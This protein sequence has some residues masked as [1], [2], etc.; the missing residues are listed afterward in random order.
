MAERKDLPI[1]PL[2]EKPVANCSWEGCRQKALICEEIEYG[3]GRHNLCEYHWLE[4]HKLAAKRRNA[5]RG[6][7]TVEQMKERCRK[8]G[9]RFKPMPTTDREP[10]QDDEEKVA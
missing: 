4:A 6:L 5:E 7:H 8:L 3:K 1:L 10:G 9:A 2:A